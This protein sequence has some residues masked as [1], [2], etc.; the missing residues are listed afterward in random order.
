MHFCLS[1]LKLSRFSLVDMKTRKFS[2]QESGSNKLYRRRPLQIGV[3]KYESR[4]LASPL[5]RE[6]FYLY[7]IYGQTR[8][9]YPARLRVWVNILPQTS[10]FE[11]GYA[12]DSR[13]TVFTK[14]K[15]SFVANVWF[16]LC[17]KYGTIPIFH[18]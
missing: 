3:C 2:P 4:K 13:Y 12:K 1:R 9:H 15:R 6:S 8:L 7:Y 18:S 14:A 11:L 17:A 10:S 5:I 16:H